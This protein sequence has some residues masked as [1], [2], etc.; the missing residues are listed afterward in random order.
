MEGWGDDD[1]LF[2]EAVE[3]IVEDSVVCGVETLTVASDKSS[4]EN[5]EETHKIRDVIK[6]I[7][8]RAFLSRKNRTL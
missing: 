8:G 6:I 1:D 4:A 5:I 7:N 3:G 2:A